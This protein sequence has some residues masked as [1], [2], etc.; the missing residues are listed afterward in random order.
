[1]PSDAQVHRDPAVDAAF[2]AL[3]GSIEDFRSAVART[4]DEIRTELRDDGGATGSELGASSLGPLARGRIDPERW[5]SVLAPPA[6]LDPGAVWHLRAALHALEQVEDGGVDAFLVDVEP[7]GSLEA[8]VGAGLARLGRAFGA[9][10]TAELIRVGRFRFEN[11]A[12]LADH[13]PP[14]MW[15]RAERT[16]APPMIA[17]VTG[18]DLRAGALAAFVDGAQKILLLVEGPTPPAPMVRLVTPGVL[19]VQTEDPNA[20]Q[21]LGDFDGPAVAALFPSGSGAALFVHDPTA[22]DSAA[23]RMS[24]DRLPDPTE[25]RPVGSWTVAQ[26]REE[27]EQLQALGAAH[28]TAAVPMG[29]AAGNVAGAGPAEV[30]PA[31]RLAS[32][33]LRQANLKELNGGA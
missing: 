33:L 9:A 32:W 18:A 15:N 24:V 12:G 23:E 16:I 25:L 29:A 30:A 19:V 22:G 31:D 1:M 20:V 10:R 4:V 17:R 13:F 27:L 11:H 2:R 28:G 3:S 5:S 14:Q 8:A 6:E 7:G 21:R 26:Q